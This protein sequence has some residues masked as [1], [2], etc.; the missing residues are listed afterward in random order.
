MVLVSRLR[1]DGAPMLQIPLENH[2]ADADAVLFSHVLERFY[3][4]DIGLIFGVTF[5]TS[6]GAECHRQNVLV[7]HEFQEFLLHLE[8]V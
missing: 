7:S 6:Q 2:L 3:R 5:R 4:I 8:W 1:D